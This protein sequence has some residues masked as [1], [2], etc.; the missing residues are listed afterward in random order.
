MNY[1]SRTLGDEGV[2]CFGADRPS[3]TD[4]QWRLGRRRATRPIDRPLWVAV[5]PEC[6]IE[7]RKLNMSLVFLVYIH[8]CKMFVINKVNAHQFYFLISTVV[9]SWGVTYV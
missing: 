5:R 6:V 8:I 9:T 7:E 3:N 1:W 2:A 4:Y